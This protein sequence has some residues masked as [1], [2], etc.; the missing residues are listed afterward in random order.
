MQV[1]L[2]AVLPD[3]AC[4]MMIDNGMMINKSNYVSILHHSSREDKIDSN[5]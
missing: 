2:H 1:H 4:N 5:M 3:T